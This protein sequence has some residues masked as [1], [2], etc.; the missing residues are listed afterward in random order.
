MKIS[1]KAQDTARRFAQ[2]CI[3]GVGV[4]DEASVKTVIEKLRES[5]PS[6]HQAILTAF[7]NFI[8]IELKKGMATVESAIELTAEVKSQLESSLTARYDRSL[9]F[10]YTITP[11]LLG[12]VKIRVGDDLVDNSVQ[13]KIEQLS[14]AF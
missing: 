9:S 5:K 1:K 4:V 8:E 2:F 7:K 12:G 14:A 11:E 6:D 3:T 10:I 13:A